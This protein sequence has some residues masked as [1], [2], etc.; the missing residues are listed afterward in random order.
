MTRVYDCFPFF[1]EL[2]L[3]EIRLHELS[4]VVD[5]FVIAE[6]TTTHQGEPKP[7][8]FKENAERFEAFGNRIRHIVV[9]QMPGGDREVDHWHREN[10]QRNALASGLDDARPEDI[11]LLS[12]IDEIPR[13]RSVRAAIEWSHRSATVHCFELTMYTYFLNYRCNEPWSRNGPRLTRRRYLRSMQG[14]RNVHPPTSDPLRSALRWLSASANMRRPIRRVVHTN[15]GW[16]FSSMGGVGML[17]QK[18]ESFCHIIP[19]RR[20]NPDGPVGDMAAARIRSAH[21]EKNIRKVPIDASFPAYFVENKPRF[22]HL[23]NCRKW[24]PAGQD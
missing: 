21:G 5:E 18:I 12:D 9:D 17:A 23:V 22:A 15:A 4:S 3:L 20:R 7:L 13:A 6:S 19:E 16:H 10:Y 1:N 2:D 24:S 8:Y 11:I 14:L